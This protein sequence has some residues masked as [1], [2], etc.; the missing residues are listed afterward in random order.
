LR[1]NE[2][3]SDTY[4]MSYVVQA[5]GMIGKPASEAIPVIE[6]HLVHQDKF[7]RQAAK[8]TLQILTAK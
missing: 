5:V 3:E 2:L 8:S 1:I 4:D 7:V 6:K